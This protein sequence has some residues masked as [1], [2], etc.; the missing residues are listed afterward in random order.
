[1]KNTITKLRG[2]TATLA[3]Y[4]RKK[5]FRALGRLLSQTLRSCLYRH[6]EYTVLARSLDVP[7]PVA[8]SH[9]PVTFH[10]AEPDDLTHLRARVSP[11]EFAR[12]SKRLANGRMCTLALYQDRLIAYGWA[13]REVKFD[14]DNLEL[15]LEPG[16]AYIDDLYTFPAYRRQRI[17]IALHLQQLR[18]LQ[19]RG[20]KRSVAIVTANNTPSLKMF[21]KLGYR[22]RGRL[23]FRRILLKRSY[24]Y[25]NG[26]F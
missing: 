10:F 3:L 1:M 11:Y 19:E 4:V 13:T 5:N 23:S 8:E 9:L 7:L 26:R 17:Q 2:F 21:E 20:F 16:E 15:Q 24:H 18:Y 12:M 6:I 14:I 22:E 25:R